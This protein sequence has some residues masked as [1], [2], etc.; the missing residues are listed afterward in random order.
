[1]MTLLQFVLQFDGLCY[2]WRCHAVAAITLP[3]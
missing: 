2:V 3:K 1:M